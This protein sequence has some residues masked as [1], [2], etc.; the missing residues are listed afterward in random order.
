[1]QGIPK[2]LREAVKIDGGKEFTVFF[3]IILP[4]SKPVLATI[5]LYV[6]LAKWNDWNT[7][8][9]YINDDNL[10]SIQYFLQRILQN[11]ELLNKMR[12]AGITVEEAEIPSET[13]RMAL[14]IFVA[15]PALFVFSFFQKYFVKGM[16]VGSVKG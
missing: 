7:A 1:M 9:L 12:D 15:G 16:T 10:I 13:V 2:E 8:M 6:F 14:A 11:L 5:A 4:L 3:K